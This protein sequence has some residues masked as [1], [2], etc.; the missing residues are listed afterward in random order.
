MQRSEFVAMGNGL[1]WIAGKIMRE[2]Y[3]LGKKALL[4]DEAE[5]KKK[6]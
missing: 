3:C 1:D 4:K 2:V 6:G 5:T